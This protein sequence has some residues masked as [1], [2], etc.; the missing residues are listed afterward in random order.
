[1][2]LTSRGCATCSGASGHGALLILDE[3]HHAAPAS[4]SRYAI[5]SQF[6]R[7]V[8]DF[9]GRFEHRLFLS[10]TP[11]NGHSNSFSTLLEILDPQRFTRGVPV[12]PRD[13]DPIMV[14]RLKPDLRHFGERFPERKVKA[15]RLQ[16]LPE[17]APELALSRILTA[18][19]ETIRR[20]GANLPP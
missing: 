9:A 14:R 10:A 18:Y 6:T 16:G 8:R 12:R 1:M 15:I 3:A 2:R 4:G 11:H 19:G 20:C 5:V 7:S 13:L 17:D